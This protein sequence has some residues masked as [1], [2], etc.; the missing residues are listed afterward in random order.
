METK[1]W[2]G[3][4]S[5]SLQRLNVWQFVGDKISFNYFIDG[6]E[7]LHLPISISNKRIVV[8]NLDERRPA[9]DNMK[10]QLS[11]R[12]QEYVLPVSSL[13]SSQ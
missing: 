3:I 5:L 1:C 10:S 2:N 4:H 7:R 11:T 6:G 13:H 8:W 9:C 12:S